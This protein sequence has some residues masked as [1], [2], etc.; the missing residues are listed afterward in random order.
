MKRYKGETIKGWAVANKLTGVRCSPLP[1]SEEKAKCWARFTKD[2]RYL[3]DL[4]AF[5]IT[6]RITPRKEKKTSTRR[7]GKRI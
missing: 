6:I 2:K 7:G 4:V 3:T 1:I 5:P